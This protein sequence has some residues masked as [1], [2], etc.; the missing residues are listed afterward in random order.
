MSA[1]TAIVQL[2]EI[3]QQIAQC[4]DHWLIR[5]TLRQKAAA[6]AAQFVDPT[7]EER[8]HP[9]LRNSLEMSLERQPELAPF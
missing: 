1:E 3:Q 2:L 7:W 9:P 8:P 6:I 4:G 5:N